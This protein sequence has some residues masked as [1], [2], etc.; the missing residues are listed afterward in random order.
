ML[1]RPIIREFCLSGECRLLP[2]R[3]QD[4]ISFRIARIGG[5]PLL[6]R[7]PMRF[8]IGAT[9]PAKPVRSLFIG[10]CH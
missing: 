1:K 4:R 10:S 7:Y 9:H 5:E 3:L 6:E 2:G 8:R